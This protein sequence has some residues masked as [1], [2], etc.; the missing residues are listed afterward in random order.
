MLLHALG[1]LNA[2]SL[3]ELLPQASLLGS[4]LLLGN[5]LLNGLWYLYLNA[6]PV[7]TNLFFMLGRDG[8]LKQ[9][10]QYGVTYL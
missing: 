3:E 9:N 4:S 10:S 1:A 2:P 8:I 5:A 6:S 7:V